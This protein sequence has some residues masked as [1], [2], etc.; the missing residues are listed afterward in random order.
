M[1]TQTSVDAQIFMYMAKIADNIELK[2]QLVQFLKE[3]TTQKTDPTEMKKV[4][5]LAK[6]KQGEEEYRNKQTTSFS[7]VDELDKYIRSL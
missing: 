3:L 6:V 5:L 4:E 2:T 1:A 7:S